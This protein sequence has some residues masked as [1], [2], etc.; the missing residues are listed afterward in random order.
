VSGA[1]RA[2]STALG[3]APAVLEAHARSIV[4][5]GGGSPFDAPEPPESVSGL[6]VS[7][8]DDVPTPTAN[9]LPGLSAILRV[10]RDVSAIVLRGMSARE[11]QGPAETPWIAAAR[12][13]V[14]DQLCAA[15][16]RA[17]LTGAVVERLR[18][19]EA[20]LGVEIVSG[21][22][23]LDRHD[24]GAALAPGARICF[25]GTAQDATG[26]IV[27]RDEMERLAQKAGLAPV[28][29]VTKTRCEVLV[30]AEAG[31]QSGKARKAQEYGK[32][33]FSA[34]EFFAWLAGK[35]IV[36]AAASRT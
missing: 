9:H 10:S 25:T 8:D 14:A 36:D 12:Q 26:Q 21:A 22:C 32:P 28:K 31:T 17:T 33:V 3:R 18:E 24:I 27:E 6:L 1:S 16:C 2:A 35:G 29:S 13:S 20:F 30:T 15:A 11:V 23:I 5:D 19:A 34:D 4:D 7:R